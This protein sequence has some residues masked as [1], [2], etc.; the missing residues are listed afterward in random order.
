MRTARK[1]AAAL[2][3]NP[4]LVGTM[5]I[6]VVIVAVYLSYVAENG[7]P[8]IPTYNI[9]VDVQSAGELIKN[10][11]VRIGGARVGQVL[12]ITPEPRGTDKG[13]PAPFARLGIALETSLKPLPYDTRYEVR[14]ASVLGGKYLEIIPGTDKNTR[15]T[16]ALPDGGLLARSN[17]TSAVQL[18]QI[19]N[20]LDPTTR[21]A[22]RT[23]Q[24]QLAIAVVQTQLGQVGEVT[25]HDVISDGI[26][27]DDF[28]CTE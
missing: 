19:F 2:F 27:L 17:V 24:Q 25:L 20:A 10:A 26:V 3:D 9:N 4:I 21:Q 13:W 12:T 1:A 5:T 11:D 6:L 23:W 18:D 16:P 14:L 15:A 7:L 28:Q 22:F 8:F